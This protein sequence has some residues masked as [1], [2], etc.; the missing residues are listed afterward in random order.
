MVASAQ[1]EFQT[2]A[3]RQAA[4]SDELRAALSRESAETRTATQGF[5]D[6]A[7]SEFSQLRAVTAAEQ[8]AI[9]ALQTTVREQQQALTAGEIGIVYLTGGYHLLAAEAL[10]AVRAISADH[11]IDLRG[12][13]PDED[14]HPVPDDLV[15]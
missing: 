6:A 5:V 3:N 4:L 15:W 10:E 12:G 14:D 7:R 11:V 8:G 1:A 9:A 2:Q 13:N